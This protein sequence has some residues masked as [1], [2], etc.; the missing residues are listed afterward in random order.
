MFQTTNQS[1]YS[2]Y[3]SVVDDMIYHDIS[4]IYSNW[5]VVWT[6]FYIVLTILKHIK[7]SSVGM[8]IPFPT[9]WKVIQNSMVRVTTN[10]LW[11]SI[12]TIFTHINRKMADLACCESK[13]SLHSRSPPRSSG[14]G[15]T[16]GKC[17]FN[18]GTLWENDALTMS[19]GGFMS[20]V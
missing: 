11:F 1:I 9:E 12:T 6:L 15:K 13:G 18:H 7:Y 17:C 5:L 10:Q 3:L 8:V 2:K 16:I 14:Y 4:S 20:Y 19:Y